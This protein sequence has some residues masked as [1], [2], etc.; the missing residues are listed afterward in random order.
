MLVFGGY[1]LV[2]ADNNGL[3]VGNQL[4]SPWSLPLYAGFLA[5]SFLLFI[6]WDSRR[7]LSRI[8]F[9]G[10][11]RYSLVGA[12]LFIVG[13][14]VEFVL[15]EAGGRPPAGPEGV[16]TPSRLLLFAATLLILTGPVLSIVERRATSG[17]VRGGW[18]HGLPTLGLALGLMLAVLTL[19]TQSIHPI[20]VLA[21]AQAEG[22]DLTQT[23]TDLY[24]VPTDGTG[25]RRLTTTPGS[26]EAHP[27]VSP[28]G[29]TVAYAAGTQGDFRLYTIDLGTGQTARVTASE[30]GEDGPVWAPDG[31]QLSYWSQVGSTALPVATPR[32]PGPA[33]APSLGAQ[34]RPVSRNDLGI[35]FVSLDDTSSAHAWTGT[36]GEGIDSWS[37]SGDEYCG[38]AY[39]GDSYDIVTWRAATDVRVPVAAGPGDAWGCSWSPD[40]QHLAWHSDVAGAFNIYTSAVDGSSVAQLTSDA[41]VNQFPRWS[42]D[43]TQ[44][45]WISSQSGGFE[46]WV[47]AA[48]GSSARDITNDPALDDGF[49]GIAW[50]P[51]G[52]GIIAASSGRVI[53]ARIGSESVPLG[54][55][56]IALQTVL[57]VGALLLAF[58]LAPLAGGLATA[59]AGVDALLMALV[60]PEP[61]LC[62]AVLAAGLA[63]DITLWLAPDRRGASFP[64]AWTG[65][66]AGVA[67]TAVYF[68]VLSIVRGLAWDL[69]LVL[70]AMMLAGLFGYATS[71]AVRPPLSSKLEVPSE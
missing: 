3:V 35:W 71:L 46:I 11:L 63:V 6:W 38:W 68:A 21:G 14:L 18:R 42:P 13:L 16:L 26:W 48:D 49:Y 5:A 17:S 45:A 31:R 10:G 43:S 7:N 52:S 70:G 64:S 58:R 41:G 60:T 57:L 54:V 69:E 34:P 1:L 23:P 2:W 22:A 51:D 66:A 24:L 59:V 39:Q 28:D 56:S 30:Q 20:V 19:L 29:R 15:R 65:V 9:P 36:R 62:L 40:G 25:S 8:P 32:T 27:D 55:G 37:P 47:A 4:F 33:P 44:L 12:A 53:P 67:F 61:V 50:L